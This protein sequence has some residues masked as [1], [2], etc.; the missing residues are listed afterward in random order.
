MA[1]HDLH[2]IR[3]SFRH[4]ARGLAE[5]IDDFTDQAIAAFRAE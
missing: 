1:G 2:A 5:S 4:A 3:S